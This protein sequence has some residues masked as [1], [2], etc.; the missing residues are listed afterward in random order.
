MGEW[1]ANK[2]D[3]GVGL[4]MV[5]SHSHSMLIR[6]LKPEMGEILSILSMTENFRER[7]G[8]IEHAT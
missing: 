8:G 1:R 7:A 3:Y 4:E 5:F 6:T 2:R